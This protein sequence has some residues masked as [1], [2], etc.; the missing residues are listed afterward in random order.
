MVRM[1]PVFIGVGLF[2]VAACSEGTGPNVSDVPGYVISKVMVGPEIDT[3]YL[4]AADPN[5][6][7]RL[8]VGIAVGKSGDVL[9]GVQFH[10]SSSNEALVV[11]NSDGLATAFGTGTVEITAS[12]DK[13]G[14]ATLVVLPAI[15]ASP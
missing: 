8:F 1:K 11:I 7:Q 4:D 3:L 12:A 2:A 14:R 5:R 6:P 13:V 9:N 10:W 15:P